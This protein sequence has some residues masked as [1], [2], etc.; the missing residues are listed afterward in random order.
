M[1]GDY[2][3]FIASAYGLS[4]LALAGL[5]LWVF[6]DARAVQAELKALEARGLQRRSDREAAR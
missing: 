1:Q 5:G 6:L 2:A 3:V 4:F